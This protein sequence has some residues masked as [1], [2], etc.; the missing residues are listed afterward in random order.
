MRL[1]KGVPIA[2]RNALYSVLEA[3]LALS[4]QESICL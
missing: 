2:A 1:A 3:A 4:T